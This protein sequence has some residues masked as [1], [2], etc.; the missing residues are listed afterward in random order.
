MCFNVATET[1]QLE[2]GKMKNYK[3]YTIS[4]YINANNGVRW[5]IEDSQGKELIFDQ[6]KKYL[7]VSYIDSLVRGSKGAYNE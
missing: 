3:G 4:K 1:K 7:C 5:S 6:T 2:A